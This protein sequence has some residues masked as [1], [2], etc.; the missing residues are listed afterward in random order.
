L[1]Q[2]FRRRAGA[3]GEGRE[4]LGVV[5]RRG[6]FLA[7]AKDESGGGAGPRILGAPRDEIE[8]QAAALLAE[9]GRPMTA[10]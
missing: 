1:A 3:G 6:E 5:R 4:P 7:A 8:R 2:R 9:A 10:G